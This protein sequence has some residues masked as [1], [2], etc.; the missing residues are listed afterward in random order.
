MVSNRLRFAS[1][2]TSD[3]A[4]SAVNRRPRHV[5]ITLSQKAS[6]IFTSGSSGDA[7][8][9]LHSYAN[10]W[11]NATG[12]NENIQIQPGDRWLLSLPLYHV[13]GLA[14]LF[15]CFLAGAAVVVGQDEALLEDVFRDYKITHVSFVPVQLKR[16]LNDCLRLQLR[17]ADFFGNRFDDLFLGHD[18][19]LPDRPQV[20]LKNR[21]QRRHD[22]FQV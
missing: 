10:H 14:I 11:Y 9:V 1:F 19:T 18:S 20:L 13:G 17:H 7:K 3:I 21:R 15:R 8:A 16:L 12:A 5:D 4:E 22:E 2:I 6:I